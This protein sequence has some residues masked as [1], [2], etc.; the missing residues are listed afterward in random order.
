MRKLYST[1]LFCFVAIAAMAQG[2]PKD[3]AGVML[4]GFYWD[5]YDDAKW[6]V[7]EKQADELSQYFDLI[8]V[9]QSGKTSDYHH[10]KRKTMGYDPCFWLDHTSCW[11]TE[12][13][14]KKMIQT[15]KDK[16]TGIIEDVVINHK[17]GLNTWVDFPDET[18]ASGTYSIQWDNTTYSA[19]CV[20]D[21]CN[22]AAN[23][24][25]WSKDGKKTAG[26]KDTGDNFPGFRDLDHTNETVQ[27]NVKTYLEFLLKEL[28]YTGF[29]Y[30]MTKGFASK[31]LSMYNISANPTY[32][33]GEWWDWNKKVVTDSLN[34]TK[35]DGKIQV[36]AFDFPMKNN[37]NMAFGGGKWSALGNAMLANDANY[38]R[39]AVT[40]VDNHDT[41]R[42]DE[43]GTDYLGNNICAANAYILTMP[44]TPCLFLPHWQSFKGTLKRLIA[45]R[46]AAGI[47][48]ESEIEAAETIGSGFMVCVKGTKGKL[49][50]HIGP[51]GAISFN[52]P[53]DMWSLA[54]EGKNFQLYA[55]KDVD[56]TA[57]KA[58][59]DKDATE[60]KIVEIPSFCTVNAGEICAFFEAP[61]SWTNT[62]YTWA[63]T[64]D[65]SDNF[66][67]G[68]W[69]GVACQKLDTAPNGN[70]VWKWTWNGKKQK[71][72]SAK[73]PDFIIFS[74]NGKPQTVN[75][76]FGN[77][78]YYNEDGYQG[79][80]ITTGIRDVKRDQETDMKVY[81][82]DGRLL[83]TAK[84]GSD[85]LNG[86]NK[87]VYIVNGKKVIVR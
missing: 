50:L 57:M 18:S 37:I 56:Q 54:L 74:N 47:T 23:I 53:V 70:T 6:T 36:A 59:K 84:N 10:T 14:L 52:N 5:S 45:L 11:G 67:G 7:L 69:P 71:G 78:G 83:R 81:T 24:K 40:F 77:G 19:I 39:Y 82:L 17:N 65:P 12:A 49:R 46:K 76:Y 66:T 72:S 16:G 30:D 63:W 62:V 2:W 15:F 9:P 41:Y 22:D 32:S 25:Q 64:D 21:E 48:N 68:S 51:V 42:R 4:Q 60:E 87:G 75:L 38:A 34:G 44:G 27:K 29:R 58:I 33:V 85:A 43:G 26:A 1:L 3:Y 28:G 20:D 79:T 13:E 8:W 86:L 35:V 55:S 80:V 61:K 73:Q 31:Y